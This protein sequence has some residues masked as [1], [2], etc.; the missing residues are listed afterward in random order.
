MRTTLAAVL[1]AASLALVAGC[2]HST[3][4]P[5]AAQAASACQS[6]GAQAASLADQA[7]KLNGKYVQ[8]ATD[9]NALAANEASQ[10]QAESDGSSSDDS[11]L[12]ALAG[13]ES[14]GSSA[15]LKV[16]KDCVSLGLSVTHH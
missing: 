13:A 4:A 1:C 15:D 5:G 3:P 2:G 9:E 10:E 8:L 12:D 11:G 14:M 7:A 16:I 6:G